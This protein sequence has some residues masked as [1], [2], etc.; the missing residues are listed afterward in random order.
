MRKMTFAVILETYM[1]ILVTKSCI[2]KR[3]QPTAASVPVVLL[4]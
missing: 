2:P 4:S 1:G 3:L